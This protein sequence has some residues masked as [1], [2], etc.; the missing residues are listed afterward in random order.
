MSTSTSWRTAT[1]ETIDHMRYAVGDRVLDRYAIRALLGVGASAGVYLASETSTGRDVVLKIPH[2]TTAGDL[3][4]FNH[5]RREIDIVSGLSHPGLQRLLSDPSEPCMVLEYV[6]GQSLRAYL[7]GHGPLPVDQVVAIGLQLTDTLEY[8]HQQGVVHRDVKPENIL[9]GP[10]GRVT[11]TDFGIAVRIRSRQPLLSHLADAVGTPDYMAPEQVRGERADARTDVYALGVLLYE[12]LTGVVPY[13]VTDAADEAQRVHRTDLPL[14][15]T[16]R[17]DAPL[18]L[19]VVL[20]RALRRRPVERYQ[21]MSAMR[22]DLAHLDEVSLPDKY[23]P[24]EPPPTPPGD[25]PPWST[26]L[27]VM[28]VI[29]CLLVLA[30]VAAE[31]VHR[32]TTP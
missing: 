15:R 6:E 18:G 26:T 4:A 25:L 7:K 27:R 28:A 2:L 12:L 29:L 20:Y 3:V 24:D 14:V 16:R 23:E 8:V 32:G 17:A 22:A 19:E 11:V 9:I 31:M 1:H 5:Y 10:D 21:S 13:P 30:G